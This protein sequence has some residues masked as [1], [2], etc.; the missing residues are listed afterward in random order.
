MSRA[1]P[2]AVAARASAETVGE[3]AIKDL[4]SYRL[5]QVANLLSRGAAMRYKRE[6]GVSL[7]EWRT[8]AL[9]GAY[10]PLSLNE[11]AKAAGLDK[12]QISRVVSGLTARGLI[13]REVDTRDGRGVRLTLTV[14]GRRLYAGLMEAARQRNERLAQRLS[15]DERA[16][17][18]RILITLGDQAREFVREEQALSDARRSAAT[19]PTTRPRGR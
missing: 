2:R 17:L 10:A 1:K 13:L 5:H 16:C 11:L 12:S 7:W 14:P 6:F 3:P 4:L 15:D 19:K 18:E 8:V 9:L